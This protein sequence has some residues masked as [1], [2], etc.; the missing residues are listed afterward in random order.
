MASFE[1]VRYAVEGFIGTIT[2]ARERSLNALNRVTL[3][4]IGWALREADGDERVRAVILTGAGEKA[5]VAG[6]DIA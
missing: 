1:N 3:D 5:F 6:A 4:E 2:V